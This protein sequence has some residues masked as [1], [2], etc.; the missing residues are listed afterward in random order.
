MSHDFV[1]KSPL[2]NEAGWIDVDQHSLRSTK[3]ENVLALGDATSTSNAKTAAAVRKQAP[4]VVDNSWHCWTV[5]NQ[6][7]LRCYGSC[8]LTVE[9][10]K[11]VLAEF[12]YGGIVK[13]TFPNFINNGLRPTS[14]AW[15]L[16]E[17]MLPT[18]YYDWMLKGDRTFAK[19]ALLNA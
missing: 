17:K 8:P 11:I 5:R 7:S 14:R 3:Y 9:I 18:L 6:C 13:P 1:A 12:E 2:A 4:V 10:G 15:W 19:P 16:K